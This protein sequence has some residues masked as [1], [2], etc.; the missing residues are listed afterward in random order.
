[1][2][3][4]LNLFKSS[5]ETISNIFAGDFTNINLRTIFIEVISNLPLLKSMNSLI[6]F[7]TD[8]DL[9]TIFIDVRSAIAY[10]QIDKFFN[11]V[12]FLRI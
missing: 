7:L 8:I 1:M 12:S 3:N 6:Q 9:R 10:V 11:L 4:C 2:H 5:C